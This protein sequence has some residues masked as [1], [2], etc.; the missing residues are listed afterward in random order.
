MPNI[1]SSR[2]FGICNDS[3]WVDRASMPEHN[4]HTAATCAATLV[5]ASLQ[6]HCSTTARIQDAAKPVTE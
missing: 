5:A 3:M 4:A 2:R 1:G 6:H